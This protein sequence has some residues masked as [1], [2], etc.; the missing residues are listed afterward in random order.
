MARMQQSMTTAERD[1]NREVNGTQRA[2]GMGRLDSTG[3]RQSRCSARL[4]GW[5]FNRVAPTGRDGAGVMRTG[6]QTPG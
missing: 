5:L 6:T 1:A 3:R 2:A 4:G